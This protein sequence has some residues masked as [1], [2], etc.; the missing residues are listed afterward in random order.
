MCLLVKTKTMRVTIERHS[1][2]SS[3]SRLIADSDMMAMASL[4]WRVQLALGRGREHE[5]GLWTW[6]RAL[7]V[8][9]RI[10]DEVRKLPR[11]DC[12]RPRMTPALAEGPV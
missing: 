7:E 1:L 2:M 11:L 5:E 3:T 8:F 6:T 12:A 10:C 9:E 4:A